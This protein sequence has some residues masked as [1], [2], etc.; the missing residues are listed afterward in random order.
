VRLGP[1]AGPAEATGAAREA[2]L[3]RLAEIAGRF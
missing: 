3:R 1:T 2:A